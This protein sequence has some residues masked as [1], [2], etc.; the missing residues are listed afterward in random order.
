M[1]LTVT[2]NPAVDYTATVEEPIERGG[3]ARTA[4]TRYD[5][6]GKGINVSKYA[7]AL[8][9]E[10]IATGFVG[11]FLGKY[12]EQELTRV[13]V[14]NDFVEMD[15]CT[16]LNTT[17][18][19]P[20]GEYKLNQS[21]TRVKEEAM[22]ELLSTVRK[23][24]PETVV[25]AGSLPP[26]LGP[27]AVDRVAN[28]GPWETIVDVPGD[29]LTA[30][31]AEYALCTPNRDELGAA[32]G[33]PVHTVDECITA[34]NRLREEGF[35]QVVASLGPDGAVLVDEEGAYHVEA[36]DSDVVDTVG[37]GDGLLAGIVA[38]RKWGYSP[39]RS[40]RVGIVLA[41]RI[42]QE[43]GTTIPRTDGVRSAALDLRLH[44]R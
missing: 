31:R 1:I 32:T 17:M 7:S 35:A 27:A 2:F 10:T 19:A 15:G 34:A 3:I 39:R 13:K 18:L 41:S 23:H 26:N 24:D 37:A 30:L 12:V 36:P 44:V 4:D 16:R 43:P 38:S 14:P 11:G 25:V 5:A 9:A 8:D 42:L 33:G 29:F 40:I 28:A 6:G 21:G 22:R 20:E